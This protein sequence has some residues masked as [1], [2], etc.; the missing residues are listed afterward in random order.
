M[1]RKFR[2]FIVLSAVLSLLLVIALSA[3]ANSLSTSAAP[4]GQRAVNQTA[5]IDE[6]AEPLLSRDEQLAVLDYWSRDLMLESNT[7]ELMVDSSAAVPTALDEQAALSE[8]AAPG[9]APAGLPSANADELAQAAYP[10]DWAMLDELSAADLYGETPTDANDV[11]GTSQVFTRYL[12][13]QISAFWTAYPY[14][15]VGKLFSS[16]GTCTATS[17]SGNSLIV[18]AAHCVYNTANNTWYANKVFSPAYRNGASPYGVFPTAGCRILP[19]Y[20]NLSGSYSING[21][22]KYDIAVCKMGLNS[23]NQTLAAAV[24]WLGRSWNYDYVQSHHDFG[25]ASNITSLY[26]TICTGE[27]FYQTTDTIGVGCD[28][29]FG[30]SGGPGIRVFAP[31][32]SG[33]NNYVNTVHSGIFNGVK[34]LYGIRFTTNN[35]VNLCNLHGC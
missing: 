35:I 30:A 25:Y 28:M 23:A 10:Q 24:G 22:A 20:V 7:L 3:S 17:I 6:G 27:T 8:A 5:N 12:G 11:N 19:A 1:N 32:Q 15:A 16:A 29:T 18:T 26:T 2:S 31:Y 13:N 9:S 33:A 14:R 4:A 34:N 21:W